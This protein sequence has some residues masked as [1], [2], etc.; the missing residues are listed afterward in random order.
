[1]R[2]T[3]SVFTYYTQIAR[4][5]QLVIAQQTAGNSILNSHNSQKRRIIVDCLKQ[6]TECI[7]TYGFDI[8]TGKIFSGRRIM[9]TAG[10][11]LDSHPQFSIAI[12]AH[13]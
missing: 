12:T 13:I 5:Q 8:K 2:Y 9:E 7:E 4:T 3:F 11:P 10:Y 1:M 6:I